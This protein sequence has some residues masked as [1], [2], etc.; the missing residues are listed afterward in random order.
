LKVRNSTNM[1]LQL[2]A[3]SVATYAKSFDGF[4]KRVA[5]VEER[6]LSDL[7]KSTP[8]FKYRGGELIM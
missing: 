7:K 2:I 3:H 6:S 5:A 1:T 8:L 4:P